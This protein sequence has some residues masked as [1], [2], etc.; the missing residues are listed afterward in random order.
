MIVDDPVLQRYLD[1]L[2]LASAVLAGL[3]VLL[4]LSLGVASVFKIGLRARLW[5]AVKPVFVAAVL[6][7]LVWLF[8]R[9]FKGAAPDILSMGSPWWDF[10]T[11]GYLTPAGLGLSLFT[12][13]GS[14]LARNFIRGLSGIL[15]T[16]MLIALALFLLVGYTM[17]PWVENIVWHLPV[18]IFGLISYAYWRSYDEGKHAG[19]APGFAALSLVAA[20]GAMWGMFSR[21]A[22]EWGTLVGLANGV[23]AGLI[24]LGVTRLASYGKNARGEFLADARGWMERSQLPIMAIGAVVGVYVAVVRPL[25]SDTFGWTPLLE[26]G[27]VCVVVFLVYRSARRT[28]DSQSSADSVGAWEGI[29]PG[30]ARTA[31]QDFDRVTR[32]QHEFVARG[33]KDELVVYLTTLLDGMGASQNVIANTLHPL[34][35][36]ESVKSPWHPFNWDRLN[37]AR[38]DEQ[39]RLKILS[40]IV[41]SVE[42]THQEGAG[43]LKR[44]NKWIVWM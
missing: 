12:F 19:L 21:L 42:R 29:S 27:A 17:G 32:M 23:S 3:S 26:W 20:G 13:L 6:G 25:V 1:V 2:V 14:R 8:A 28:I 38:K 34:I 35:V 43:S 33:Q 40:D 15:L 36:H 24:A 10:Q 39:A 41:A 7:A 37:L 31:G 16:D 22:G 4:C 5:S 18:I 9:L 44:R 11:V 30:T